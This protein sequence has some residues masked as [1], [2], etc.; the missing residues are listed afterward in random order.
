MSKTVYRTRGIFQRNLCDM[1]L[2][3]ITD[4]DETDQKKQTQ[5]TESQRPDEL[6]DQDQLQQKT[7]VVP[8]KKDV[9]DQTAQEPEKITFKEWE[10][11]IVRNFERYFWISTQSVPE[12]EP[13]PKLI[14][15]RGIYK[16]SH[17]ATQPWADF[18]LRPNF[19][20]AMVVV[21]IVK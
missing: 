13:N 10:K 14:N 3:Y 5:E 15:L 7:G 6:K 12:N 4:L 20:V 19:T 8:D 1:L 9:T 11:K 16:D 18:Q 2:S 17:G 21:S